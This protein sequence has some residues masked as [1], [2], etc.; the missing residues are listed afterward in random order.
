MLLSIPACDD[1]WLR[2]RTQR[3]SGSEYAS[4]QSVTR[5]FSFACRVTAGIAI[6]V[7]AAETRRGVNSAGALTDATNEARRAGSIIATG[8]GNIG[9][10]VSKC[11]R[12]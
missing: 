6:A 12:A 3:F 9:V 1:A 10:V 11:R 7:R 5:C 8:S 2:F 4:V